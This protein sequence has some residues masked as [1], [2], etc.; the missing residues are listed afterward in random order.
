MVDS[1]KSSGVHTGDE[2]RPFFDR[3]TH[4]AALVG[5]MLA[6]RRQTIE[7]GASRNHRGPKK[8]AR[9][10]SKGGLAQS[11]LERDVSG[12]SVSSPRGIVVATENQVQRTVDQQVDILCTFRDDREQHNEQRQR[13]GVS[14]TTAGVKKFVHEALSAKASTNMLRKA[15]LL[16]NTTRVGRNASHGWAIDGLLQ[17]RGEQ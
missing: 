11:L 4:L 16:A 2:T 14:A 13:E 10:K 15:N 6:V 17:E 5:D 7:G 12:V 1:S 8:Q 9:V 3:Q